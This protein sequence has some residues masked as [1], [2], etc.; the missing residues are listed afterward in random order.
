MQSRPLLIVSVTVNVLL[1]LGWLLLRPAPQP[2]PPATP[3][4]LDPDQVVVRTNVHFLRD[5]F[6]WTQVESQD[7]PTYIDNLR[8]IR[9]PEETIRDIII[10]D[11]NDLFARRMAETSVPAAQQWWQREPDPTW[12]EQADELRRRLD[13]E[14]DQLLTQLL[15]SDWAEPIPPIPT[16]SVA[17]P[18][19][20]AVLGQL[21]VDVQAAIQ[22]LSG[23]WQRRFER[24]LAQAGPYGLDPV[25]LA[26]LQTDLQN[27]LT[28][29]L[30][31]PQLDEFLYRY[32][33]VSHRLSMELESIPL[34]APTDH[35]R[36]MLFRSLQ[37]ID[38]ALMTLTGES[39]AVQQQRQAL[40][41]NRELALRNALGPERYRD[42]VRLQD[43]VYQ[44]AAAL[45]EAAGMSRAADLF[46]AIDMA[47]QATEIDI[48][49][50]PGLTPLQQ[51][52]ALLEL[53]RQQLEAAGMLMGE[54]PTVEPPP[55]PQ[56]TYA[57][58]EGDTIAAISQRTG[59]PVNL[60]L[61]ANP[62][63]QPE[64]IPPGTVI[65]LPQD[66]S[67]VP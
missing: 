47:G 54:E 51:E 30:T 2:P 22:E 1:V 24:I 60:I 44:T 48:R 23:E 17:V 13:A 64:G 7:Y 36:H 31:A 28:P 11:V 12:V 42:Y 4:S 32:S 62:G 26:A 10:A 46:Y 56:E 37:D 67:P 19:E 45:A 40:L 21:S 58:Q 16:V 6:S 59:I 14:R 43:P 50:N 15:G 57:F 33:P 61:R 29:L 49:E 9:C 55:I 38:L 66:R 35:E 53:Q 63:L 5:Y 27:N 65:I 8:R 3:R 41:Q 20:G 34:F 39:P 25:A 18:L 52:I